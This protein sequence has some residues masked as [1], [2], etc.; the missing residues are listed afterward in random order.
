MTGASNAR[1]QDPYRQNRNRVVTARLA[2]VHIVGVDESSF[3]V[4]I[5][6]FAVVSVEA[7]FK[8]ETRISSRVTDE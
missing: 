4:H 8:F 2:P 6:T 1:R 5:G 3:V 7:T